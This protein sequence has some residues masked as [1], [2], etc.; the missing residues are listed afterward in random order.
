MEKRTLNRIIVGWILL[1]IIVALFGKVTVAAPTGGQTAANFL[2]IGLGA[3]SAGMGGAFTAVSEG[4]PAAYWNPAGLGSLGTGEV[5][6]SHFAWY[7]DVTMEQGV[8]AFNLNDNSALAASISFLNYGTIDGRDDL[9]VATGDISVYDW[10]GALSYS[11]ATS[12]SLS[13]GVTGKFIN[14]KLDE[15]SASTFAADFGVKYRHDWLTLAAMAANVGPDMDF[16]GVSEQ[17]PSLARVGVAVNLFDD[18][19]VTAVDVE[20]RFHGETVLR[21]GVEYGYKGQYFVRT[22]YNFYP[23]QDE[24]SFGSGPSFGMGVRFESL[25]F[26]YAYTVQENY[27]SDNL[28][29]FSVALK[30]GK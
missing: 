13:F 10:Y 16:E 26:D 2:H 20:K 7:Q 17:L 6:L 8:V 28:H 14:Q 25:E 21:Q 22:G 18:Q 3:R 15:L 27:T 11:L 12:P 29:R 4:A 1:L 9:G 19:L 30:F 23:G 24:R 5:T